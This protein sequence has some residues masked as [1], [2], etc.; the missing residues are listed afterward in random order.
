MRQDIAKA[1]PTLMALLLQSLLLAY[2]LG[3][4]NARVEAMSGRVDRIE[5]QM[6]TLH[7][8]Q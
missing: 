1:W 6:D 4:L 8:G 5:T 7:G 2:F 3:G